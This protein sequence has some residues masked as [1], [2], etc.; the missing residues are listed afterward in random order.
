MK[1]IGIALICAL[2][3]AVIAILEKYAM[4]RHDL[5]HASLSRVFYM[6]LV[7]LIFVVIYDPSVLTS[8]S[9]K[10]AMKDP[11]IFIIAMFTVVAMYTYY[12]LLK[13]TKLTI[14]SLL[15][16]VI[17]I[18]TV[19]A[20]CLFIKEKLNTLQWIG[21]FLTFAGVCI[22]LMFQGSH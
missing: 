21:I 2:L 22:T 11:C 17:M 3:F 15:S 8:Q 1:D 18:L 6:L 13:N 9:F 12:H 10:D 4:P 5:I 20:A 7:V 19:I 16:P 14:V